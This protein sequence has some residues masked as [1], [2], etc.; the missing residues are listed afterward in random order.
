MAVL[1]LEINGANLDQM[2]ELIANKDA[3]RHRNIVVQGFVFESELGAHTEDERG[4]SL[5]G[6]RLVIPV[7]PIPWIPIP[8]L[9]HRSRVQ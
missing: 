6:L 8:R 3:A 1:L 5:K 9:L 7:K 2:F 4:T